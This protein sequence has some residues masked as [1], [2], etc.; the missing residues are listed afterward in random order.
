MKAF[1]ISTPFLG[2]QML[3]L[4]YLQ[5]TG[6][7]FGAMMVNL[8]RQFL[9]FFPLMVLL[10]HFFQVEGMIFTQPI[11]DLVTTALAMGFAL[12]PARR[13]REKAIAAAAQE[14]AA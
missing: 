1:L 3:L 4:S 2:L 7:N 10:N 8:G 6:K 13:K 5:A 9:V 12:A 11:S 14:S